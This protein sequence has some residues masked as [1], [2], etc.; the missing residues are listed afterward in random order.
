MIVMI[1]NHI[2]KDCQDAMKVIERE[3]LPIE[4][5][6]MERSLDV[7]KEFLKIREG[8]TELFSVC[9][10]NNSIGIPVFV[11]EDGT[12]TL[13]AKTAF[14]AAREAKKPAV[15]MVG[16]HLCRACR[17]KL[18]MFRDANLYVEFHDIAENLDDMR[19]FLKIREGNEELYADVRKEGRAGIPVFLLPDGTVTRDAGL[20][21][22]TAKKLAAG[23]E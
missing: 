5:K 6:D 16:S 17:E 12:V 3:R 23:E 20:A 13:D 21:M 11:L 22:E 7:I 19:M 8:N 15:V 10:E 9:R 14:A 2:C 18:A 4:F 1:G